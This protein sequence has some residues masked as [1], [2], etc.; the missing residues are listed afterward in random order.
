MEMRK[1]II[2][3]ACF[4]LG[5]GIVLAAPDG[6]KSRKQLQQENEELLRRLEVLEAEIATY[7]SEEAEREVIEEASA[8]CRASSSTCRVRA[9][10]SPRTTRWAFT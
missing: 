2:S 7:R 9:A 4:L 3:V 5:A 6:R 8:G 10:Y 1:Y